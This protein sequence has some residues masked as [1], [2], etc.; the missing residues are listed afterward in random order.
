M[1]AFD[2]AAKEVR[3]LSNRVENS[4]DKVR[5]HIE[6]V[7]TEIVRISSGMLRVQEHALE[8]Q[9][10]IHVTMEGFNEIS[11]S[12]ENLDEQAQSFRSII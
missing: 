7:R 10:Q 9:K 11:Q 5:T 2:V 3:K 12:A 4:I 1:R 6:G 8:S